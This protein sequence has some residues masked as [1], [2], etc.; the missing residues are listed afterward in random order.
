MRQAL[1]AGFGEL[2]H[3]ARG[4]AWLFRGSHTVAASGIGRALLNLSDAIDAAG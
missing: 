3:P 1:D 2:V 4:I